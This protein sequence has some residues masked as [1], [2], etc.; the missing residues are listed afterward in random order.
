MK[1]I[2]KEK[3]YEY[4][5]DYPEGWQYSAGDPF[6]F[7]VSIGNYPCFIKRFE[8]KTPE[9][10][11]GW[12]LLQKL[13]GRYEPHLVRLY[14][15]L[16]VQ[17]NGKDVYY[18]FFEYLEG[19]TL[20]KMVSQKG[21]IDLKS[22]TNDLFIAIRSLQNNG[23]WFVD[24]FERNI[25]CDQGGSYLLV[26]LDS[27][28]PINEAPQNDMYGNKDYWI[29]VFKFYQQV[30]Q[31]TSIKL[32]DI[33][34]ISFN[35]IQIAFLVLRLKLH[36]EAGSTDYNASAFYEMLPLALD[37][38]A[39]QLKAIF[40]IIYQNKQQ[41]ISDNDIQR[42][43]QIIE[44]DIIPTAT[45]KEHRSV[46]SP[47][48]KHFSSDK[49]KLKDKANFTL[50][51][52][53][54][55]SDRVE[56]YRNN[57]VFKQFRNQEI[58][59]NL[60][61]SFDGDKQENVYNLVAYNGATS[62]RSDTITIRKVKQGIGF[63][64]LKILAWIVG[65]IG[66]FFIAAVIINML[67]DGQDFSTPT[68]KAYEDSVVVIESKKTIDPSRLQVSFN[69]AKAIVK[70]S[71]DSSLTVI[72]PNLNDT[73]AGDL[74]ARLSVIEDSKEVFSASLPYV[75]KVRIDKLSPGSFYGNTPIMLSGKNLNIEDIQIYFNDKQAL[76][77][78][79]YSKMITAMT[80][81]LTTF[82]VN[83]NV[84]LSVISGG[85]SLFMRSYKIRNILTSLTDNASSAV[86]TAGVL[87]PDQYSMASS[88]TL[89]WQNSDSDSRGF[90]R[91]DYITMEDGNAYWALRT[92]PMWLPQGSI[93]GKFRELHI[94]GKKI[95]K[96]KIG[97]RS[98]ANITTAAS[99][100]IDGVDFQVWLH[101]KLNDKDTTRM[102]MSQHKNVDFKLPDVSVDFPRDVPDDFLIELKVNAGLHSENDWACW[103]APTIVSKKLT[104]PR[105][106]IRPR[107]PF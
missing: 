20:D 13:K 61:E 10:I 89:D 66:L 16:N 36:K 80:P 26:D 30:L 59:T 25:F 76:M 73:T 100:F 69:D 22:L 63:L 102:L 21:S 19:S 55:D 51:W 37:E 44:T 23:F 50:S 70:S 105:P 90:A 38:F 9:D 78:S 97:F 101:Y 87:A 17:E 48:I 99:A 4:E 31:N 98:F 11:T 91:V 84:N 24:F 68:E 107:R 15:I 79:K 82:P 34:G 103:I 40:T 52:E 42:I 56:L 39:P 29:L 62:V 72:V 53:I 45:K 58:K 86:W 64:I 5:S 74:T 95:F 8:K 43:K 67:S 35:Y 83:Q 81:D 18:L 93:S 12:D 54:T 85:K 1:V 60:T 71:S 104:I 57:V 6:K 94:P 65:I 27:T 106:Y 88:V 32:S 2:V 7:P 92:H 75:R 96:A 77:N 47:A 33:N 14:D 49:T 3:E 41:L 28:H 46:K